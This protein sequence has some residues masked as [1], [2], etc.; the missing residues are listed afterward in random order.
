[1]NL[2]FGAH[3]SGGLTKREVAGYARRV[4]SLGFDGL[5]ITEGARSREPLTVLAAAAAVTD[6][7]LGTAVL[8][9]P[10]RDPTLLARQVATLDAL[11]GGKVLLGVG[12]GGER[13]ADFGAYGSQ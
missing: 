10:F 4:E 9:A 3:Y 6:L 11:S 1:M 13:A 12:V 7:D 8:L 5:W 2:K